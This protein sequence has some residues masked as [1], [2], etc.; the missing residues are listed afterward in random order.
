[1]HANII[2]AHGAPL[3]S[4]STRAPMTNWWENI[5]PNPFPWP[6]QSPPPIHHRSSSSYDETSISNPTASRCTVISLDSCSGNEPEDNHHM[7]SHLL[8]NGETPNSQD[9]AES[10]MEVLS[11]KKFSADEIEPTT[12]HT[13]MHPISQLNFLEIQLNNY[14]NN[15]NSNN[16][17]EHHLAP[18]ITNNNYMRSDTSHV[19]HKLNYP[20]SQLFPSNLLLGES[21]KSDNMSRYQNVN[22]VESVLDHPY[23]SQRNLSDQMPFGICLNKLDALELRTSEPYLKGSDLGGE[24]KQG[25]QNS[26]MRGNGRCAGTNE[27]KRKR[28]EDSSGMHFRKTKNDSQ[29]ISSDKLLVPKAKMAEKISALQQLV[30][31]FGKTDQASVLMETINCITILQKQVQLLTDPY[32]KS[33]VSKERNSWGETE[34]KEKAEAKYDLRSKGLCLVPVSSIPQVHRESIRPDYWMPTLRGCFL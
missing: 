26:S 9:D 27:G 34:R 12:C 19:K 1:M 30:S 28:S 5:R 8:L 33:I 10:F 20:V 13:L 16:I 22:R 6:S 25:Y 3:L 14:N 32:L 31:P 2:M 24:T 21:T 15:N 7:W 11:S 18:S 4:P 23:F 29:M 17:Q